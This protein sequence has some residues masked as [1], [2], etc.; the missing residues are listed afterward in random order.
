[1]TAD[2]EH[3]KDKNM[4]PKAQYLAGPC[5]AASIPYWKTK[6]ITVPEGMKIVHQNVFHEAEY[7]QYIDEPYFRLQHN[8]QEISPSALPRG[9]S[10]CKASLCDFSAHISSCYDGIGIKEAELQSY[11]TRPVFDADLWLAVK[12]DQTGDIVATGIAELDCEIGEGVLEWIQ[13][14]REHRRKGL[15]SCVVSE[16][17]RR[18]KDRA[19]FVT[20]SGQCRNP[21]NP[22]GLYRRCGFTGSDVWHILRKRA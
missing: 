20:V 14:S 1:M 18:M 4:I 22:E 16:L 12:D 15:G 6:S 8:L 19:E 3:E 9:Y 2:S 17:L 5:K 7:R 13:V 10:F 21:A 11:M